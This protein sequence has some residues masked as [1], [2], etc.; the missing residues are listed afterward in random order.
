M[1]LRLGS[2]GSALA[3]AQATFVRERLEA[4]GEDVEVVTIRT[5]GD[6][7][8]GGGPAADM[9]D[10]ARFVKEIE[11][12]LLGGAIDLAV[13]SAKDVPGELPEGLAIV[14]VP[15]RADARDALCGAASI[16]DL[17]EGDVVGTASLRRRAQLL[18]LRP[19]LDVRDVRGNVDTRLRR[20]A[21]GDYD[22][23]VLAAAGLARLRRDE[24]EPIPEDAMT[25]APG[26][27]CLALEAR[28]DD[29]GT[30]SLAATLT[31][32]G[33]LVVLTAERALVTALEATCRTP[34]GAYA[35]L[36]GSELTLEAFAGMPDGSHWI[37]DS[38][39]GDPEDPAALGR[40]V[41]ER[42]LAAGA[43]DLLEA[44]EG[45]GEG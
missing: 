4:V 12:A 37:R 10:K 41:G 24:G 39:S 3:V 40:A 45:A 9:G 21:E 20:L 7:R 22:A 25:P 17:A 31:D 42:M 44:A 8:P 32:R 27:G 43:R 2:R 1:A 6:E 36:A 5:S 23:L 34:V 15:E 18:A 14:G 26:Q 33:S 29:P 13:H 16:D 30:A 19:E 28:S 35:R 38:G 11:D